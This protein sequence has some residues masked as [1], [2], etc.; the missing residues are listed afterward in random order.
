MARFT[1]RSPSPDLEK[2][3]LE[4]CFPNINKKGI[5][6]EHASCAGVFPALFSLEASQLLK[7]ERYRT[8]SKWPNLEA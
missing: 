6:L 3:F 1:S 2:K 5:Y 8:T 4:N 7:P